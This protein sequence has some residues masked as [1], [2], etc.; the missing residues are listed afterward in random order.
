MRIIVLQNVFVEVFCI[1]KENTDVSKWK[2]WQNIKDDKTLKGNTQ[3]LE[4]GHFVLISCKVL[5]KSLHRV[6]KRSRKY[7]YNGQRTNDKQQKTDVG[8]WVVTIFYSFEPSE[9]KKNIY[10]IPD[11][12]LGS[13]LYHIARFFTARELVW[14]TVYRLVGCLVVV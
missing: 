6:W 11:K 3:K 8:R 7:C 10:I 13:F 9:R 1:S 12:E 4:K 5:L 14:T 2:V